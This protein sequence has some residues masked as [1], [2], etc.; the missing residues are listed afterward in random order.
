MKKAL[1]AVGVAIAAVLGVV[2]W[3]VLSATVAVQI[4]LDGRVSNTMPKPL[5]IAIP[6]LISLIGGVIGITSE[7]PNRAKGAAMVGIGI[8]MLMIMF[9]FNLNR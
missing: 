7:K 2:S 5:A 6:M 3:F 8:V 1:Y 9:F 4:G